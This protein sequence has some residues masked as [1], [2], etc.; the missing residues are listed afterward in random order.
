MLRSSRASLLLSVVK[1]EYAVPDGV[2]SLFHLR[3]KAAYPWYRL[4]RF[5]RFGGRSLRRSDNV[6]IGL[7]VWLAREGNSR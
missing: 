1:N 3:E 5:D 2:S 4:D 6:S 7:K